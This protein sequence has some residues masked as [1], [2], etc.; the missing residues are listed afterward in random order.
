MILFHQLNRHSDSQV[1]CLP[2]DGNLRFDHAEALLDAALGGAGL[3][4]IYNYIAG[5]AIVQGK[6]KPVLERYAAQG[7]P[8]AVIYPQKRHLSAKVRAFV[9]FMSELMLQL[10][11]DNIVE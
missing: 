10:R 1:L 3:I 8:I 5:K 4:Q 7:T 2:V 11:Q 6:L 9:N